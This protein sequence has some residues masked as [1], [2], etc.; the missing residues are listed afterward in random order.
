MS[1]SSNVHSLC[2]VCFS[3]ELI[4]DIEDVLQ[5]IVQNKVRAVKDK[6]AA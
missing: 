5:V 4:K 6:P 2:F 1:S 3:K